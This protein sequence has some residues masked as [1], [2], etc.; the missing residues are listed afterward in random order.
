M[1]I[2][3]KVIHNGNV[4]LEDN[5]E[6]GA[7][8]TLDRATLGSTILRKGAKLDNLVQVAHNVE[9]GRKSV[10]AALCWG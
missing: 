9:I 10:I 4:I 7:N 6:I 1:E 2:K 8:C 5:V 3:K